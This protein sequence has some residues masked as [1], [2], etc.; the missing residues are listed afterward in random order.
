MTQ[1]LSTVS[2]MTSVL[3]MNGMTIWMSSFVAGSKIIFTSFATTASATFSGMTSP[4]ISTKNLLRSGF[5]PSMG[6]TSSAASRRTRQTK[7]RLCEKPM[8]ARWFGR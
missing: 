7:S 4:N 3:D 8:P 5:P 1:P 2:V 6:G